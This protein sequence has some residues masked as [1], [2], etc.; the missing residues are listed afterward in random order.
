MPK[1][2]D[3]FRE[4]SRFGETE[5]GDFGSISHCVLRGVTEYFTLQVSGSGVYC[6]AGG[7]R[8]CAA[9]RSPYS[10]THVLLP[11][12]ALAQSAAN[13]PCEASVRT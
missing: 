13:R 1:V 11:I 2:S 9:M 6:A 8:N 5:A 3:H 10:T 4:N 12:S 7:F